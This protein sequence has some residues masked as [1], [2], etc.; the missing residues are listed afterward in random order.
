MMAGDLAKKHERLVLAW[1][2][3]RRD[4]LMSNW[5][6]LQSGLPAVAVPPLR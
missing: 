3:L 2:E 1:A 5:E 6:R 4:E